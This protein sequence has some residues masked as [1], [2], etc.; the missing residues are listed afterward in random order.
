M[1]D[2]YCEKQLRNI[3]VVRGNPTK[4]MQWLDNLYDK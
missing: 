4:I 2:I 1:K 3:Y